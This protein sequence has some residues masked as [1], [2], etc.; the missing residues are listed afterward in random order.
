MHA[1]CRG[2]GSATITPCYEKQSSSRGVLHIGNLDTKMDDKLENLCMYYRLGLRVM[3]L[4]GP[5]STVLPSL[6]CQP[7]GVISRRARNGFFAWIFVAGGR[8]SIAM[9]AETFAITIHHH[10][11]RFHLNQQLDDRQAAMYGREK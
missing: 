2:E 5:I 4:S 10:P 9:I 1:L 11:H 7:A 8:S 6:Y 3:S